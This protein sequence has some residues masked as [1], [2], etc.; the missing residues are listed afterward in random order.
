M[1][2]LQA[3]QPLREDNVPA[4]NILVVWAPRMARQFQAI[5]TAGDKLRLPPLPELKN[6]SYFTSNAVPINLALTT[7][8]SGQSSIV[9]G[10]FNGLVV[11]MRMEPTIQV[12]EERYAQ[13]WQVGYLAAMRVDAA[14]RRR[15]SF[16]VLNRR[17]SGPVRF[18]SEAGGVVKQRKGPRRVEQLTGTPSDRS[19]VVHSSAR[20][21]DGPSELHFTR[22]WAAHSTG[23]GSRQRTVVPLDEFAPP[24]FLGVARVEPG[25]GEMW[26]LTAGLL[27]RLT[28][29]AGVCLTAPSGSGGYGSS[30]SPEFHQGSR[31]YPCRLRHR[32][33][34]LFGGQQWDQALAHQPWRSNET[35]RCTGRCRPVCRV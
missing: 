5:R 6:V 20:G 8:L 16:E 25:L 13:N 15:H 1:S 19:T 28:P 23:R 29:P 24:G 34:R 14:P 17:W 3:H 9:M 7:G 33:K 21:G 32:R 11:G 35:P 2:L 18:A 30:P 12:L 31:A 4:G 10:D 26:W 22:S 27:S